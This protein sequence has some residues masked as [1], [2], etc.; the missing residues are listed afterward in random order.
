[1]LSESGLLTDLQQHSFTPNGQP[2]CIYGDMAYPMRV[3]LQA[4]F[5]GARLTPIEKNFNKVMSQVRISVE[6]VFGD[7]LDFFAFLDF[8]KKLKIGLIDQ[9]EK[10]GMVPLTGNLRKLVERAILGC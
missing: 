10:G 5:K 1:M 7:I 4:P 2:L 3:H 6:W 8:R 9:V